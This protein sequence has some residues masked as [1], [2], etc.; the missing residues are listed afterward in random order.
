M[1]SVFVEKGGCGFGSLDAVADEQ[2]VDGGILATETAVNQVGRLSATL[3]EDVVAER[4]SRLAVED[5]VGLEVCESVGV[6]DFSP[7][8]GVIA[9]GVTSGEDVTELGLEGRAVDIREDAHLLD[10]L[11]LEG[12][13]VGYGGGVAERVPGHIEIAEGELTHAG[14][15]GAELRRAYNLVDKILRDR[16]AGYVVLGERVEEFLLG[17][18]VLVELRG[19]FHEIAV[20][21]CAGELLIVGAGEQTVEGVAEFVKESLNLIGGEQRRLVGCGLGEVHHD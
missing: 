10:G 9:C 7:F 4:V 1:L 18:I 5:A 19:E 3:F 11:A 20:D 12:H 13:W 6:E 21:I 2:G 17:E 8:V 15:C 14:V 16:F